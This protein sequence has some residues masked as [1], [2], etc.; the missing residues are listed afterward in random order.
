MS[1]PARGAGD[2]ATSDDALLGGRLILRQP[3]KGHRAGSDAIL[4]AAAAPAGGVSR[5]VDV[6]A[7]VGAVGLAV[8]QRLS[9]ASGDLIEKDVDLAALAEGNATLNGLSA[10]ARVLRVNITQADARREAGLVDGA[11]DLV[12]TNPPFFEADSVRASPDPK[13][14][15]A[16]VFEKPPAGSGQAPLETWVVAC[17]ALLQT[18]G[19]FIL[20]HRPD[21]LAQILTAFGRRLGA[22]TILPIYPN[23]QAPA[24]R[25]L[26]AGV[27]GARGPINLRPGLILHDRTGAFTPLAEA[28]HRG[29]ALID[30]GEAKRRG[31]RDA[32]APR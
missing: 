18:G 19:H 11:A 10:R 16:H 22:V 13:R 3:V 8:L 21:A 1:D 20:I 2:F 24:H 7:G 28:L 30:W 29:E 12:V 27:K 15:S 14:A 5:L 4:L 32:L 25:I 31:S 6:G 17:L 9:A 26:I 23:A